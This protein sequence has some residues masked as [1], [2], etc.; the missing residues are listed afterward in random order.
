MQN[1]SQIYMQTLN[2]KT[3]F[4]KGRKLSLLSIILPVQSVECFHYTPKFLKKIEENLHVLGLD[5]GF[6]DTTPQT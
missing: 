4:F 3:Y 1:A 5:K 2:S 6:L